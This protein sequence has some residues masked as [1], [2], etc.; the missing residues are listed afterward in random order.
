MNK[1]G[2]KKYEKNR[3]FGQKRDFRPPKWPKTKVG[4]RKSPYC[5]WKRC[6]FAQKHHSI[7]NLEPKIRKKVDFW[8]KTPFSDPR[9]TN[10]L[11]AVRDT[12]GW[13]V[14]KFRNLWGEKVQTEIFFL[15]PKGGPYKIRILS[16]NLWGGWGEG[17]A[18]SRVWR[19]PLGQKISKIQN[20]I[21]M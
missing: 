7:S 19:D 1:F 4:C 15:A 11:F 20:F 9:G 12:R 14:E 18:I 6:I 10:F 2:V 17:E 3:F 16:E 13:K 21:F 8:P 5:W